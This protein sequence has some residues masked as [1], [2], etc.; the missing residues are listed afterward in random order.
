MSQSSSAVAPAANPSPTRLSFLAAPPILRGEDPA[1]YDD[2][3]ARISGEIKPADI[4]EEI[5]LHEIVDLC[6]ESLRWRRQLAG[7]LEAATAQRL[8]QILKPLLA[9]EPASEPPRSTSFVGRIHAAHE[10]LTAGEDH[11]PS[12]VRQLVQRFATG[13]PE[14]TQRVQTLLGGVQLSLADVAAQA[15]ACELDT[16]ERFNRLIANTQARRDALLHELE[17]RRQTKLAHKLR[18]RIDEIEVEPSS[19]TPTNGSMQLNG[20]M[21]PDGSTVPNNSMLPDGSIQPDGSMLMDGSMS[22]K[23]LAQPNGPP[24]TVVY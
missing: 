23:A 16:V 10:R 22:S 4:F 7:Y 18:Q 9:S 2:L 11:A 6:W 12:P 15:T 17:R 3:L 19:A 20:S 14:A 1:A 8:E 5:W 24:P 21:R 13:A